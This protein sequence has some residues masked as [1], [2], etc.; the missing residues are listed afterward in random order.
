MKKIPVVF[1]SSVFDEVREGPAIYARYLWDFFSSH[2]EI[3]FHLVVPESTK[4]HDNIHESGFGESSFGTYKQLQHCAL[5][6]A[7]SL[8]APIVH[9]NSAH[10][11]WLFCSYPHVF[12]A[13]VNDYDPADIFKHTWRYL[14]ARMFRRYF[15][16]VWRH[17]QESR[18]L[19]K[20]DSVICNSEY[21][22][23]A[24]FQ[25]YSTEMKRLKVIYKAVNTNAFRRPK[26]LPEDPYPARSK[27]KRLIFVGTNWRRKGLDKLLQALVL[28]RQSHNDISLDIVGP[29]WSDLS[30]LVRKFIADNSLEPNLCLSGIVSREDLPNHLWNADL[31]V[32]PS[33]EEALGVSILEALAAGIPVVATNVGGI[34]EILASSSCGVMVSAGNIEELTNTILEIIADPV[35]MQQMAAIAP[36]RADDFSSETMLAKIEKL[37]LSYNKKY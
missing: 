37:Y 33:N 20:A 5:N 8:N 12:L 23:N 4:V 30:E 14:K 18:V 7:N 11:M 24:L 21:T 1:V 22:K 29:C 16:L 13:Q 34:P 3:D 25:S 32:L 26:K 36:N 28:I 35:R 9:G 2:Q 15:A 27:G 10:T 6:L 19:A 31:A 17:I